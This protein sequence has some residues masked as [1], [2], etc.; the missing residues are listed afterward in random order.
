MAADPIDVHVG[1]RIRGLRKQRGLTQTDLANALGVTFQQVQKYERGSNRVSAS[2]MVRAA[3]CLEVAPAYFFE[4]VDSIPS[5]GGP[6]S[7][8]LAMAADRAGLELAEAWAGI[9][10]EKRR[11]LVDLA[12]SLQAKPPAE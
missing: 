2:M 6:V 10:S 11:V 9:P 3:R 1:A 5:D 12:K 7:P 4:G 8:F